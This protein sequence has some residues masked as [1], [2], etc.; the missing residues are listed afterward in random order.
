L[1]PV[2]SQ[3]L[4]LALNRII[5][6]VFIVKAT[7]RDVGEHIRRARRIK[8]ALFIRRA[9]VSLWLPLNSALENET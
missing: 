9:L 5:D 7:A 1:F 8:G 2:L 3:K 4:N 6:E